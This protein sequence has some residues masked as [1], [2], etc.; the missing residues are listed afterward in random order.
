[1]ESSGSSPAGVEPEARARSRTPTGAEASNLLLRD[2]E[3][4]RP[5]DR[6]RAAVDRVLDR[7]VQA[8]RELV[9]ARYTALGIPDEERD[10]VRPVPPPA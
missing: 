6:E 3:R 5:G 8:A 2:H 4:R 9:G 7:L 10:R 1:M